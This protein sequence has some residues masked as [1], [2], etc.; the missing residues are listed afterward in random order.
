[1]KLLALFA[2]ALSLNAFAA[3]KCRNAV[4]KQIPKDAKLMNRPAVLL[5]PGEDDMYMMGEIWNDLN[6]PLEYYGYEKSN[7]Y[8]AEYFAVGARLKDCKVVREIEIGDDA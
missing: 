4:A 5:D 1:M 3:E 7:G 2:L 6:E 8:W